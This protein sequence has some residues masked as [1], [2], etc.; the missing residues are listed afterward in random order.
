[1]RADGA[2]RYHF[3]ETWQHV[4]AIGLEESV[5]IITDLLH[6]NLIESIIN[7]ALNRGDVAIRV[8]ATGKVLGNH[9]RA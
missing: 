9:F 3:N 7:P 6:E 5:Q 2:H 4:R 1:M 8:C